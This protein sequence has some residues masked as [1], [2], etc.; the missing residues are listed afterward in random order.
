MKK[1]RGGTDRDEDD[2]LWFDRLLTRKL[3]F[4]DLPPLP[5]GTEIL[6]EE[7]GRPVPSWPFGSRSKEKWLASA[8]SI[9]MYKKQEASRDR[10]GEEYVALRSHDEVPMEVDSLSEQ[11]PSLPPTVTP[12]R[13]RSASL[14]DVSMVS[15][16][17]ELSAE[18]R[19][20]AA[21]P[22]LFAPG[23]DVEMASSGT[24]EGTSPP[25]NR[26]G[27]LATRYVRL[28]GMGFSFGLGDMQW[29][30]AEMGRRGPVPQILGIYR[31]NLPNYDVDYL[32][33][34]ASVKD[35]TLLERAD[36]LRA[37]RGRVFVNEE[38][39]RCASDSIPQH[40]LESTPPAS[41]GS[42]R[43][44]PV[45]PMFRRN[46]SP[47]QRREEVTMDVDRR[48]DVQVK[49]DT[50]RLSPPRG[51]C[52]DTLSCPPLGPRGAVVVPSSSKR[53]RSRSSSPESPRRQSSTRQ[54]R[55]T[56]GPRTADREWE[57]RNQSGAAPPRAFN[58]PVAPI[59]ASTNQVNTDTSNAS[60]PA[61]QAPST[62]S[63]L[64]V[65]NAF[66]T[67]ERGVRDLSSNG[68][69]IPIPHLEERVSEVQGTAPE[70][71]D[72]LEEWESALPFVWADE[73]ID[74]FINMEDAHS[75]SP[76]DSDAH[77]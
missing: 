37:H 31:I 46:R 39:F 9:W 36:T 44:P 45:L 43:I 7:F 24:R 10:V 70:V 52:R 20:D 61:S 11:A 13:S 49:S 8:P 6:D 63:L 71:F 29:Q 73:E 27:P 54:H 33:K 76:P 35:A 38:E 5:V 1:G 47:L 50:T 16:G 72:E 3:I 17:E 74:W 32:L 51:P 12:A 14:S 41:E 34:T 25:I 21:M 19:Q 23:V 69:E 28:R 48:T 77:D 40:G 22:D 2:E 58:S 53:R 18:E 66:N 55:P 56:E 42:A 64:P 67:K 26:H 65:G 4:S 68:S 75:S 60:G 59:S 57:T 30:I 15:L 62:S